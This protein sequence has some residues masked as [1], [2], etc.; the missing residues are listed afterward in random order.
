[1]HKVTSKNELKNKYEY[2]LI[3]CPPTITIYTDSALMASDYYLIPNRLDRYSIVGIDSLQ[4]AIINLIEEEQ[5]D[6]K[7][8]GLVYTMVD[9]NNPT[10]QE[11]L[12]K[13]FESKRSVSQIEI[14]SSQSTIVNDIQRGKAGTLPT[15]Y[16]NSKQDIEAIT[17]E[18]IDKLN[19]MEVK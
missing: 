9:P 13:S 8:V 15:L 3:D 14:F 1:M 11:D 16:K 17:L 2:I 7:C 18:L 5:I 10:K 4:A 12:R 19:K 6:L